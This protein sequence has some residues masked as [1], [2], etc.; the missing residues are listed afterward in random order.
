M[1]QTGEYYWIEFKGDAKESEL[2]SWRL[3]E[4]GA[5]AIEELER[6]RYCSTKVSHSNRELIDQLAKTLPLEQQR[7]CP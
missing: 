6:S 3:F 2:A 5:P 1:P 4:A 7:L